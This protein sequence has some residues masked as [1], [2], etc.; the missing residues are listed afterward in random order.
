M[1]VYLFDVDGTLTPPRLSMVDSFIKKFTPFLE[2]NICYIVSGSD[3]QKIK[4]QV[5]QYVLEKFSG[6][7]CSMGNELFIKNRCIYSNTMHPDNGLIQDLESFRRNTKY[8]NKLYNNYIENRIGMINFSILGRDCNKEARE[9][10]YCWDIIHKE[11]EQIKYYLEKK[12]NNYDISIG[13]QISID[14]TLKGKGKEQSVKYLR[15]IYPTERFIFCGDKIREGGNDYY[16]AQYCQK[17]D[18]N[19]QVIEV[20][21]PE[22]LLQELYNITN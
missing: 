15:N 19:S 18:H 7:F 9:Q 12:Y 21:S 17:I 2:N 22:Q 5:P 3:L 4:E 6:I 13:G 14:I 11:R 16:I 1:F 8:P 10:Y 20:T